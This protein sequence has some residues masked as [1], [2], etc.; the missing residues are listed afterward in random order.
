M[1][2]IVSVPALWPGTSLW[3][4]CVFVLTMGPVAG[5]N[6]E[7][8][9]WQLAFIGRGR[10]EGREDSQ[11]VAELSGWR[12]TTHTLHL[13]LTVQCTYTTRVSAC[14][15]ETLSTKYSN[16]LGVM[17]VHRHAVPFIILSD[18]VL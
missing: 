12:W 1:Y 14:L 11:S 13:Y 8:R 15:P 6:L 3:S 7:N 4:M 17:L 2:E 18:C 16:I 10:G 9:S 5:E